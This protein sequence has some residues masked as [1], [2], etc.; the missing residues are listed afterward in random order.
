MTWGR[1][2]VTANN[3]MIQILGEDLDHF[4]GPAGRARCLAHIVN[5]VVKIILRQFDMVKKGAEVETDDDEEAELEALANNIEIERGTETN[6]HDDGG[7]E[8]DELDDVEEI[9]KA[10]EEVIEEVTKG[11]LPVR[12]VLA[13][14][15]RKVCDK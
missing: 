13:K 6:E 4:S 10:M 2:N 5:L 11:V 15:S 7:I 8:N 12:R 1:D 9:E 14:A 3:K